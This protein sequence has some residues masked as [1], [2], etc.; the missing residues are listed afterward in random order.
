MILLLLLNLAVAERTM[1]VCFSPDC[2]FCD[3]PDYGILLPYQ[4]EQIFS[5]FFPLKNHVKG[6]HL[7][8]SG[9]LNNV[10]FDELEFQWSGPEITVIALSNSVPVST[11]E[12]EMLSCCPCSLVL[13]DT[14][15]PALLFEGNFT[16]VRPFCSVS[17]C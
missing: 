3:N 5:F 15:V 2:T 14:T 17:F 11:Q 1:F 8:V 16:N 4:G 13:G 6:F 12:C 7:N 9:S 10:P